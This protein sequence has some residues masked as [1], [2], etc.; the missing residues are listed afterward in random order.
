VNTTTKRFARSMAEAFP[1]GAEYG[2]AIEHF[3]ASRLEKSAG[4]ALAMFIGF[5]LAMALVSWW[6][7]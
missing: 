5:C 4:V 3:P 2:N 1:H 7:S 6:S